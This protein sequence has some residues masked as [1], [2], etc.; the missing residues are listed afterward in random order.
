[1]LNNITEHNNDDNFIYIK[2]IYNL[3]EK[4]TLFNIND[5]IIIISLDIY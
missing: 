3:V 5:N 2:D 4:F 1:M